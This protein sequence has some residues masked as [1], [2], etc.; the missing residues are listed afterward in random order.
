MARKVTR[1]M[2]LEA[3]GQQRLDVG[4]NRIYYQ[5][6][7][8]M[9]PHVDWVAPRFN[10]LPSWQDARR[11]SIDVETK[12]DDLRTLGPGVRR[13]GNY[14]C[15]IA[16]AIEDGP[17]HYLPI[18]H[19]GGENCEFD[20]WGYIR[21][22][23]K[24]F[25]GILT[26]AGLSYDL[27]WMLEN[28]CDALGHDIRDVQVIDP[29]LNE[30]HR[31][32]N[33]GVLCERHGLPGKDETILRQAASA[34]RVDPKKQMWRLP[35]KYVGQYAE[36]D[37]RR[38]LQL[39]R[40]QEQRLDDEDTH[41]I[42][43]LERQV[44]PVLVKMRRR[45]VRIDLK[46]LEHIDHLAL[47]REME[48]LD[49][50]KRLSG[51]RIGVGNVWKAVELEKAIMDS[52]VRIPL[53][54]KTR[55]P[56][57]GNDL[58][59]KCG[60]VGRMLIRARKWNKL[61]TTFCAQVRRAL[62]EDRVH[63]TFNQLKTNIDE[64]D[65]DGK[66][67]RF[68][69]FSSTNFNIQQQPIRD[70][71]FGDTWRAVFVADEDALWACSDWSQQEPRIGVHY[72]ELLGLKGAREFA[73]EYRRNPALDIHQALTDIGNANGANL[74]RKT[75]KNFVNGRLYGMGDTKL[76]QDFGKPTTQAMRY[77][78]M[79]EVPGPE[80]QAIIDSFTEFAPWIAGLT[81][82]AARVAKKRGW[83]R[84]I[85]GR[86]LHFERK[87]NGEI[88]QAHKAFNRIGQGGAADQMKKTLVAA[89]REGIPVQMAVHD[90]FDFSFT[91]IRQARRL[92]EL[93]MHT[94]RFNGP[95]KVDLEIGQSWGQLT[96]DTGN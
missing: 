64:R 6:P 88:W 61:R 42:W 78:S 65:K 43:E 86:V 96:K 21:E 52:G 2:R 1:Y 30:L 63:C 45:G 39:L 49:E 73:D 68:G 58:L 70:N 51:V 16:F 92:K 54:P 31:R 35:A 12:D 95:M 59:G 85:C 4:N 19:H 24:A 38:P 7:P 90:E 27:D 26:G 71:E 75:V 5:P 94:V 79:R 34:Y 89:D 72:A 25:D 76:C 91:D 62:V 74:V 84:T 37:A 66:G 67:V 28:G 10:D 57:I 55:K 33:L 36:V 48:F 83:V 13:P 50:V 23:L 56:S 20:V 44:T 3:A 80:G 15:G 77:G 87:P 81:R 53:T 14:V 60:D 47:R 11:V 8:Q 41:E 17:A 93:Q 46:H 22:Q 40:R 69:R 29:L 9:L 18:R 82:Y 32:Y